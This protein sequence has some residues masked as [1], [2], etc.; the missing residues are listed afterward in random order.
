[1]S[2]GDAL[3]QAQQKLSELLEA[4]RTGAIIP[5]R[6]PTQ[7]EEIEALLVQAEEEQAEAQRKA[8]VPA[9]TEQLIKD[10]AEFISI[11]VHELRT[12]MTSIR[13]YSDMLN[14]PAM[15]ELNDMQKQ[16]LD[17]IRT[18][19][20]RMEG[21]LAD[22]SN[23]SKVKAHTLKLT[24]KMDMFK[25]I[26][27]RLE[28]Q[29]KPIAEELGRQI[30]FDV[31]Q[32]LPILNT[33]GE[34]LTVAFMKM[35]ENG[36]RYSPEGDGKV[37]VSAAADGN[38]LVVTIADNGVGITTEELEQLGTLYFRGDDDLVNSYKGSG[39]GIPIAFGIIEML[40]G[41]TEIE[42]TPGQG[43]TCTIRIKG[44]S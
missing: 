41:S 32:G 29:A 22:V 28:K 3:K 30:E 40:G 24:E 2:N 4:A 16:F 25:N 43:T 13:G 5:F 37:T 14:T 19:T 11:A 6:L 7:I 26:A 10:H 9:D 18:N 36:L 38:T 39:L 35:I 34:F 31:P 42:S 20:K 27:M 17:V 15:G 1:M 8:A 12:P 23:V 44:M 21:L 33:D